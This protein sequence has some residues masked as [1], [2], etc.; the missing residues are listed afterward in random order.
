MESLSR[1]LLHFDQ[2]PAEIWGA[3]D[4]SF[5]F[6]SEKKRGRQESKSKKRKCSPPPPKE[7][8][9]VLVM[10]SIDSS[11]VDSQEEDW[12]A[13][14]GEVADGLSWDHVLVHH[15]SLGFVSFFSFAFL[16]TASVFSCV[17]FS[18]M[19]VLRE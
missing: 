1:C 3:L 2:P 16:L 18:Y 4:A 8:N 9:P 7:I 6:I 5:Q 15:M 14:S 17:I 19:L 12:M 11:C 13:F 10:I